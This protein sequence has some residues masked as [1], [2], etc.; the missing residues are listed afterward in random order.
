VGEPLFVED[1][2]E[3]A[4]APVVR[5]PLAAAVL[6]PDLQAALDE[7]NQLRCVYMF[8][9]SE[10]ILSLEARLGWGKHISAAT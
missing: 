3:D 10:Y 9:H 7:T 2:D 4:A 1:A 5:A 8:L 6:S